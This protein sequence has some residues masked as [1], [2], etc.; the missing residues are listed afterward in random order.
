MGAVAT[1]YATS[2]ADIMSANK[3]V[4][5]VGQLFA[6]GAAL[7]IPNYYL[8]KAGDTL[9]AILKQVSES[10]LEQNDQRP[11]NAGVTIII[12][13]QTYNVVP[14]SQ[15]SL[16]QI[17]NALNTTV[18]NLATQNPTVQLTTSSLTFT[19]E[20][21][22]LQ[23]SPS[24]SLQTMADRFNAQSDQLGASPQSVA[25]ANQ[26]VANIFAGQRLTY[27]AVQY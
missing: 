7:N 20:G 19:L 17:A 16:V 11:L 9:S 25:V 10:Q 23:V 18:V 21:I 5:L 22:S 14:P 3:T 24:D 6:K 2:V 8:V 4:E 13:T 12:P 15:D 27:N 1:T 26:T